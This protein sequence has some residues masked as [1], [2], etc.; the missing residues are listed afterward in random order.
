VQGSGR[1]R[2]A[3]GQSLSV[4]YAASNGHSYQ[5]IGRLLLDEGRLTR[6][7]VSLQG[8]R[9]YFQTYPE[10]RARVLSANPRYI[11]FRPV[12]QGPRGSLNVLLVPGRSIATDLRLFPPA[13]LAFIQ[14]YKPLF[15][16]QGEITTWQPFSRFVFNHDTGSA[17][18]GPGRVDLFWGSD[19]EAE[20][21]A[22]HMQHH[23]KLFFLVARQ[24]ASARAGGS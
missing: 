21:A 20:L 5:S 23:G 6:S 8:L 15:N 4:Q 2:F 16:G 10:E 3:D 1:V 7:E 22:G 11:F 13:G 18:T 14:T 24:P 12:E 9:R 19:A 17:I